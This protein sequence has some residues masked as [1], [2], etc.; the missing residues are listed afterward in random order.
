M[1]N[2]TQD[3]QKLDKKIKVLKGLEKVCYAGAVT[4]PLLSIAGEA[5]DNYNLSLTGIGLILAAG[6]G[7]VYTYSKRKDLQFKQ[8]WKSE[9]QKYDKG[10]SELNDTV[11]KYSR[12]K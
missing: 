3:T 1:T 9:N 7:A 10:Y 2:K 6:V 4:G 12:D 8:Y 5:F 11:N